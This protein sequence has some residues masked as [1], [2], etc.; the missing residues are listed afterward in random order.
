MDWPLAT[1]IPGGAKEEAAAPVVKPVPGG[2]AVRG[3]SGARGGG[4]AR[5]RAR[6]LPARHA[7]RRR[8]A[9]RARCAAAAAAPRASRRETH[10]FHLHPAFAS[11]N[12]L[13]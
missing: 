3:G 2:D 5:A 12:H 6:A 13:V 4:R 8:R 7:A 10:L 11:I 9:H 1:C